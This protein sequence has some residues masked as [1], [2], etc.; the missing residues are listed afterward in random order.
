MSVIT[1]FE[2]VYFA[3]IR[4]RANYNEI[5]RKK[6]ITEQLAKRRAINCSKKVKINK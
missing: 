3:T 5:K 2:V 1:F 4:L 6:M